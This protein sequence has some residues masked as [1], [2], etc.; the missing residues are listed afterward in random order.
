MTATTPPL[1]LA[2]LDT[3]SPVTS[4]ALA[5]GDE[6]F[7]VRS[8]R[9][10]LASERVLSMLDAACREAGIKPRDLEGLIAL[11]GPGS[12]TGLRVGLATALGVHWALGIR[13]TAVSTLCVL[14]ASVDSAGSPVVA[15]VDALR[16]EWTVQTFAPGPGWPQPLDE[17]RLVSANDLAREATGVLVGFGVEALASVRNGADVVAREA[18]P[19]APIAAR[20]AARQAP[21]WDASLL[22]R[23]L[24][25]RPPAVHGS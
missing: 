9:G 25:A 8:E 11:R 23:P 3:G 12:F 18:R 7:A 1:L 6:T 19:L 22:T 21:A 10:R 5:R 2:A 17:P 20:M 13:A 15:A 24:Y 14:A 16:G 4:V